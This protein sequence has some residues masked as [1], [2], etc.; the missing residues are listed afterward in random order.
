MFPSP[1]LGLCGRQS[2]RRASLVECEKCH[3][4]TAKNRPFLCGYHDNTWSSQGNSKACSLCVDLWEAWIL[5]GFTFNTS[6]CQFVS[7]N[8]NVD[9]LAENGNDPNLAWRNQ[10]SFTRPSCEGALT[11]DN[12]DAKHRKAGKCRLPSIRKCNRF[13]KNLFSCCSVQLN[14]TFTMSFGVLTHLVDTRLVLQ[15][16]IALPRTQNTFSKQNIEKPHWLR[17]IETGGLSCHEVP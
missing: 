11:P 10:A 12:D 15:A 13:Q 3:S 16:I 9:C 5:E 6:P 2:S 8:Q 1:L 17:D 4:S 7:W 14:F